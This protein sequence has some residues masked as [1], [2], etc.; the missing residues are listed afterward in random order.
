M[1]SDLIKITIKFPFTLARHE[2]AWFL[3]RIK[4]YATKLRDEMKRL[5]DL[6]I[7]SPERF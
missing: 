6:D 5:R 3:D 2:R 7:H 4:A 1:E